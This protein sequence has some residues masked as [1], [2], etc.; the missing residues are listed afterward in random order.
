M[1]KKSYKYKLYG[2]IL[3]DLC[4]QPYELQKYDKE[5]TI[6]N[7]DSHI[8]DDTIMTLATAYAIMNDLTFERAYKRFGEM[9][10]DENKGLGYGSNFKNWINEPLGGLNYSF[11]NGCLMRISPIMYSSDN[12]QV[13]DMMIG[14][15]CYNSH[16]HIKSYET[17]LKLKD[18]YLGKGTV[19]SLVDI[20]PF[21]KFEVCAEPT[22]EFIKDL[23]NN[24]IFSMSAYTLSGNKN[25]LHDTII[26]TVE[27]KGDTDTNAS[28]IGE[29][30]NYYTC[31][32]SE[33]DVEYVENKLR[34]VD[35]FL[36]DILQDFNSVF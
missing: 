21:N 5:I 29:L 28:I 36:L 15:S 11:G 35:P 33:S 12:E 4:G 10:T 27:C 2:A 1:I 24:M 23:Y 14:A 19:T 16:A 6:H 25:L 34:S 9:Y 22:F 17:C 31:G 26:K 8:T 3:G 30:T 32:I 20:K 13:L 7:P 18:L